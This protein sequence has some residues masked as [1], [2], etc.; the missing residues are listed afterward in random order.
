M[1]P[2]PP[3]WNVTSSTGVCG[4]S[5]RP[6]WGIRSSP[7]CWRIIGWPNL[8]H[9]R[10]CPNVG[11][12]RCPGSASYAHNDS[13]SAIP[14]I[15][16]FSDAP[17]GNVRFCAVQIWASEPAQPCHRFPMVELKSWRSWGD[18]GGLEK[19]RSSSVNVCARH[20]HNRHVAQVVVHCG[21]SRAP[22]CALHGCVAS[23]TAWRGAASPRMPDLR[24]R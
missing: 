20:R 9:K 7:R 16:A 17:R 24:V 4:T 18:Y 10:P 5:L 3:A 19:I 8:P 6:F 2:S 13:S 22:D 1:R 23:G 14:R 12:G 11:K 15:H 21:E